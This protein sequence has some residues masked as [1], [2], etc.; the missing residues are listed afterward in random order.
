MVLP[1]APVPSISPLL[2]I[3]SHQNPNPSC[4]FFAI[5]LLLFIYAFATCYGSSPYPA[6]TSTPLPSFLRRR[7]ASNSGRRMKPRGKSLSYGY[8]SSTSPSEIIFFK[9]SSTESIKPISVLKTNGTSSV[10]ALWFLHLLDTSVIFSGT[11][12]VGSPLPC[13]PYVVCRPAQLQSPI[14]Q[15]HLL[16]ASDIEIGSF[17]LRFLPQRPRNLMR[18]RKGTTPL[19]A[20]APVLHWN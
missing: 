19:V 3:I 17:R 1:N 13:N 2:Q 8:I 14:F 16:P 5:F 4:P 10:A 11:N 20:S 6:N 15:L 12:Q 9:L 18:A 7:E